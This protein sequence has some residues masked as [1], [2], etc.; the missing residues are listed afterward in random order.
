MPLRTQDNTNT[1]NADLHHALSRIR[2]HHPSVKA[3]GDILGLRP[4]GHS[5]RC[6]VSL[7]I[8]ICTFDFILSTFFS[9]VLRTCIF[10]DF[11]ATEFQ[12]PP[13]P[14]TNYRVY[15]SHCLLLP[16][17]VRPVMIRR[18]HGTR[19]YNPE[20]RFLFF[21]WSS[22]RDLL[23]QFFSVFVIYFVLCSCAIVK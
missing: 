17:S 3:E 6:L 15:V 14:L 1:I 5:H 19:H 4:R 23:F 8:G 2:T 11:I 13:P 12:I 10:Q 21:S 18:T 9:N 7:L 20:I 22:R 16:R